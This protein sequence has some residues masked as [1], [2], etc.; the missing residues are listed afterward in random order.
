MSFPGPERDAYIR[1]RV[2]EAYVSLTVDEI[3]VLQLHHCER[4]TIPEIAEFLGRPS[5]AVEMNL[6]KACA[7]F[8]KR[9]KV[10][11]DWLQGLGVREVL[12]RYL[13]SASEEEAER[14]GRRVWYHLEKEMKEYDLEFR[15]LYRNGPEDA[16]GTS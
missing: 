4:L 11:S 5:D 3:C 8:E 15:S 2:H 10:P 6:Q 13:P 7:E 9:L 12:I 14:S 1:D 16:H